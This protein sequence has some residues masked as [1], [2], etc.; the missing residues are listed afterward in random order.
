MRLVVVARGSGCSQQSPK[1][2]QVSLREP[3]FRWLAAKF[4]HTRRSVSEFGCLLRKCV[5]LLKDIQAFD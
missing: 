4:E 2:N 5:D 3:D 1:V